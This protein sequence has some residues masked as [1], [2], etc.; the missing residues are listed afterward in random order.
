MQTQ[1]QT[2][3]HKARNNASPEPP[4]N[5]LS[6]AS[7]Q[8]RMSS[9]SSV[10]S[11]AS[12]IPPSV[13]RKGKYDTTS[14]HR[15]VQPTEPSFDLSI[16]HA[17]Y[18]TNTSLYKILRIKPSADSNVIRRAYLKQ[19]RKTLLDHGI[20]INNG[21][22]KCEFAA[23]EAVPKRL[24]DVPADA[25]K[26]FQAVSIAYEILSTPQLRSVYDAQE[27]A[28]K[29]PIELIRVTSGNSVRWNPYVEEKIIEDS[30]PD[31]HSHRKKNDDGWLHMH[32]EKLD[33]EAQMFLN[34]DFLDELDES[35]ASMS[36]SLQDSLGSLMRKGMGSTSRATKSESDSVSNNTDL[37]KSSKSNLKK[38]SMETK[39]ITIQPHTMYSGKELNLR[40]QFSSEIPDEQSGPETQK[41]SLESPCSV[42]GVSEFVSDVVDE[43]AAFLADSFSGLLELSGGKKLESAEPHAGAPTSMVDLHALERKRLDE[44]M[45]EGFGEPFYCPDSPSGVI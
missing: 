26:K 38:G 13:L 28:K 41:R 18:G 22:G 42:M 36:E 31:E 33:D 29:Q 11:A 14:C 16:I 27:L 5:T 45:R 10:C 20:A 40:T 23:R 24:E 32:L 15:T 34:G 4:I 19:G 3:S 7:S 2:K 43:T 17:T 30:H 39:G 6:T 44:Q 37:S 12:S 9:S 25:R 35:I 8:V 1:Q 21:N